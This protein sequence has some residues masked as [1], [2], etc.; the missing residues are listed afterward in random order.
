VTSPTYFT[1]AIRFM[2]DASAARGDYTCAVCESGTTQ[3]DTM[4]I[5]YD[6]GRAR[7]SHVACLTS[8]GIAVSDDS[9]HARRRSTKPRLPSRPQSPCPRQ[10]RRQR[11][12]L[13]ASQRQMRRCPSMRRN[14]ASIIEAEYDELLGQAIDRLKTM[15]ALIESLQAENR[16]LVAQNA[17]AALAP[18]SAPPAA[19]E[20]APE[21][22][23]ATTEAVSVTQDQKDKHLCR[24]C[25]KPA[26]KNAD[27]C[28]LH[29]FAAPVA[30]PSASR[31]GCCSASDRELYR[32]VRRYGAKRHDG[33]LAPVG[34]HAE[35]IR[36]PVFVPDV[37][38]RCRAGVQDPGTR[39]EGPRVPGRQES[40]GSHG[41]RSIRSCLVPSDS[42]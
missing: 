13:A 4:A 2:S 31:A 34:R 40:L 30:T 36:Q 17:V 24:V 14:C 7:F 5:S 41:A 27:T 38:C 25:S 10:R 16:R 15:G 3:A 26:R 8:A 11:L 12:S 22:A 21:A 23:P 42:P 33:P 6:T 20:A 19:T 28:K 35:P 37:E 32:D 39:D 18:A 9:R 29:Q 1:S